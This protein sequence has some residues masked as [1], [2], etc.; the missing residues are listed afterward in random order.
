MLKTA[1]T[2]TAMKRVFSMTLEDW[3]TLFQVGSVVLLALTFAVGAGAV[4]TGLRLAKQQNARVAA[5]EHETAEANRIAAE[6]GKGTA[7]ALADA[8]QAN[9]RAATAES[10]LGESNARAALAEQHSA[11][12]NVIAARTAA[13]AKTLEIE[14]G[15]QRE[16]A[17]LAERALLE[18]Q[19]RIKPRSITDAERPGLLEALK[20][21]EPKGP[22]LLNH[23]MGDAEGQA[24]AVQISRVLDEAGWPVLGVTESAQGGGDD[25]TGLGIVIRSLAAPPPHAMAL[26]RSLKIN[27]LGLHLVE[28]PNV[29]ANSVVILVGVK[30]ESL[31][32]RRK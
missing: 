22:V 25:P 3:N 1:K 19:Q 14:A 27:G 17:A 26:Q 32:P 18:L 12:A 24:F 20:R 13:Q 7:K 23:V 6:A 11:E 10:H 9:E 4:L 5:T 28:Y 16:R 30:P 29:G 21:A 8:A 15:R 31:P 2:D